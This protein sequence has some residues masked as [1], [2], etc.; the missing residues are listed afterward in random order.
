MNYVVKQGGHYSFPRNF[1]L[2]R[3]NRMT[4]EV[5]LS[6]SWRYRLLDNT[7]TDGLS[8]DQFDWNKLVG[9]T[10]TPLNPMGD[11]CM[12]AIR[13][14]PKTDE[15]K[16]CPYWHRNSFGIVREMDEN[17]AV[18][19][20]P[21]QKFLCDFWYDG[22]ELHYVTRD[23]ETGNVMQNESKPFKKGYSWFNLCHIIQV[24]FG[25]NQVAP[26]NIYTDVTR[27]L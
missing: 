27:V 12:V 5:L 18:T 22:K 15:I 16:I 3:F 2:T 9:V 24:Y 6:D 21:N 11:T 17:L 8:P 1:P 14:E 13:Y 26:Q 10:V 7:Q 4:F 23:K 20:K 19:I 25:G